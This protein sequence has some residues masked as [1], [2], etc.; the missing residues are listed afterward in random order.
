MVKSGLAFGRMNVDISLNPHQSCDVSQYS[1]YSKF[2][3]E[4]NGLIF[5]KEVILIRIFCCNNFLGPLKM[6]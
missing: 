6:C 3:D 2:I 1:Q 4:I 5:G